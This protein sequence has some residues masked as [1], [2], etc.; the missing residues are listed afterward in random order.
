MLGL[1]IDGMC[2]GRTRIDSGALTP[3]SP[4]LTTIN[5]VMGNIERSKALVIGLGG[6][7][8]PTV[9]RQKGCKRIDIIEPNDKIFDIAKDYFN[10]RPCGLEYHTTG[11]DWLSE[12]FEKYDIIVLDAYNGLNRIPELYNAKTYKQLCDMSSKLYINFVCNHKDEINL[13]QDMLKDIRE[14]KSNVIS[15]VKPFQ[16]LFESYNEE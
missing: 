7:I 14:V 9:M 12:Y 5:A 13:H 15:L 16:V 6:G 1:Y 3:I 4:Y 10:Y 8:T 11:Q 2:Q